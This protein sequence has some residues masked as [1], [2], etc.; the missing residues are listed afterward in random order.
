M[1]DIYVCSPSLKTIIFHKCIKC[2]NVKKIRSLV[3]R[4][5]CEKI[6][7]SSVDWSL[8]IAWKNWA[9]MK[10]CKRVVLVGACGGRDW[11]FSLDEDSSPFKNHHYKFKVRASHVEVRV[12]LIV[13]TTIVTKRKSHCAPETHGFNSALPH[14]HSPGQ[15]KHMSHCPASAT[16][17]TPKY[18]NFIPTLV[19]SYMLSNEQNKDATSNQFILS[20]ITWMFSLWL[21]ARPISPLRIYLL[22]SFHIHGI[23]WDNWTDPH[24]CPSSDTLFFLIS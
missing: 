8:L 21:I 1:K 12:K 13:P 10:F 5:C 16:H 17:H 19:H 3:H 23:K 14:T 9:V 11:G 20:F 22:I 18:W 6:I 15:N 24:K 4:S 7:V 2:V